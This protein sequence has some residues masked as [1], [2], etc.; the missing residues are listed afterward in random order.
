AVDPKQAAFRFK[1]VGD[2]DDN[3]AR[4]LLC[5]RASEYEPFQILDLLH[6]AMST[7]GDLESPYRG[8]SFLIGI[9]LNDD[10]YNDL[11]VLAMWGATGNRFYF[12]YIWDPVHS[13]F[14][15]GGKFECHGEEF[16]GGDGAVRARDGN[17]A[18][19]SPKPSDEK[20]DASSSH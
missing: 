4:K 12:Y 18:E 8:S 13:A 20:G 11:R 9:D 1:L 3:S 17:C 5:F 7:S 6:D 16:F 15:L 14:T 19:R 10:G 2:K